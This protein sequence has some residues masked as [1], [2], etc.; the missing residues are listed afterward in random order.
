MISKNYVIS[1]LCLIFIA[2]H[3]TNFSKR[4]FLY[5]LDMFFLVFFWLFD[6]S[7]LNTKGQ[8]KMICIITATLR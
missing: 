3:K 5:I 2:N 1:K 6:R 7:G 4:N 8:F